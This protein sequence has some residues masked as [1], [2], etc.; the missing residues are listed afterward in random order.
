M[1]RRGNLHRELLQI[2]EESGEGTEIQSISLFKLM[3]TFE[4]VML[5]LQERNNQ[6][7]HTVVQYN[8]TIEGSRQQMIDLV[9][10]EKT[11]PFEKIIESVKTESMPSFFFFPSWNLYSRVI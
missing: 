4:K 11:V 3:K 6:P 8:Y 10:Q 9:S 2:G 7:R 1:I 5:R